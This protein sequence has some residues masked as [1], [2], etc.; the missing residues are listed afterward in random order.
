MARNANTAQ[1]AVPR[2]VRTSRRRFLAILPLLK[3][4]AAEARNRPTMILSGFGKELDSFDE[5]VHYCAA[6]AGVSGRTIYRW[7]KRF[8][9]EGLTGLRKQPRTD[10]DT[11]RSFAKRGA[12]LGLVVV[13]LLNGHSPARAHRIL[14]D[15]WARLYRGSRPPSF[16]TI[17]K[18][19]ESLAPLL[20]SSKT[21]K[22]PKA[23]QA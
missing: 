18:L 15:A 1:T 21:R 4:R 20:K 8:E 16:S 7:L 12:A 3:V 22:R 17:Y 13:E 5:Q 14:C 10:K 6:L 23:V 19:R 11:F 9:R 2:L